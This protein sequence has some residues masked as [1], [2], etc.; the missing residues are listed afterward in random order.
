MAR[1]NPRLI[2]IIFVAIIWKD[3]LYTIKFNK[4]AEFEC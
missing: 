3:Q 1:Y 4:L 2:N